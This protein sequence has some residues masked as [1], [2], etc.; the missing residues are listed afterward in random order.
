[1]RA[2]LAFCLPFLLGM[3]S[4]SSYA[5]ID[6]QRIDEL[7]APYL[8]NDVVTGLT[9]GVIHDGQQL[10]QGYG[11]LSPDDSRQPDG[12]TVY[13][14]GSMSK[15]FTGIL[16]GDAVTRKEITLD[17]PIQELL[18]DNVQLKIKD[19]PILIRHLSTHTSGLPR[20]PSNIKSSD[21]NNP[22]ADYSTE[23]LHDYLDGY[24][25]RLAPEA[26][27]LYSNLA[28]GFLGNL[29]ARH[30]GVSY[31]EL[32]KQRITTP[33]KMTDT[34]VDFTPAMKERLAPPLLGDGTTSFNWDFDALA[35]AGGIRSTVDDMLRFMQAQ[36][37]PPAGA[38]GQ[39][40]NLAWKVHWKPQQEGEFAMG[41]GWH[42]ARDGQ[43]RWH[44]G[45]TGG[46]H[47]MMLV[48]REENAAVVVLS[49]TATGE[50]DRL[51]ED[52]I[53]MLAGMPV[54]PRKFP[55][56]V[57]V[58]DEVLQRYPGRYAILPQFVLTITAAGDELH[59]Q[60][61][62]QPKLRVFPKS[63]TEWFY[64]IVDAQITFD[65]DDEGNCTSLTLHQNGQ[66]MPAKRV[67]EEE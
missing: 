8:E 19:E 61:T 5:E 53:R 31:D 4:T 26:E 12:N 58:A 6:P 33:L 16:L 60:A 44:N 55:K 49:N 13:E 21:P 63:D 65:V 18:P 3:F 32:L 34:S 41:L 64:K 52:M 40:I 57:E 23:Q 66:D 42:V 27:T 46:Y 67:P 51:A 15:V 29:L 59:V 37:D 39:A 17:Q 47:S 11:Q 50:V 25:P 35:G 30:A 56:T 38:L 10:S 36:L 2:R 1:M 14:I 45:Q 24:Q 28:A 20:M 54:Q 62:G 9:V 48:S 7:V 22:Y 43:T